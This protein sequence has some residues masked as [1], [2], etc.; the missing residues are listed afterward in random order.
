MIS[1]KAYERAAHMHI[2]HDNLI[3]K[4]ESD[5]EQKV[6]M[7]LLEGEVYLGIPPSKIFTKNYLAPTALDKSAARTSGYYPDYAIFTLSFPVLV[8][9]AKSP[10]VPAQVGYREASL[11]ARHLNQL[12]PPDLNPCRFV[13]ATN[14]TELL[15]GHW[16]DMP[17]RN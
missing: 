15:F 3:L 16:D 9:E 5:V 14:G 11:Y 12:Y 1:I 8:V 13:V 4:T 6:I 2:D 7:P 10:D 17:P